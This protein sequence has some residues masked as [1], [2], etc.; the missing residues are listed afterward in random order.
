MHRIQSILFLFVLAGLAGA[1]DRPPD[2]R[3][4]KTPPATVP[5]VD[6]GRYQ[7]LWYEIARYPNGFERDCAGVTAEYAIRPDG[8]VGVTNTCRKGGVDGPVERAQGVARV[9]AGSGNARLTVK[10]APS[11]V[12]FAAGDYWILALDEA[13]ETALVGDPEGRYLWI[14]ARTP[15]ISAQRF[16]NMTAIAARKGYDPDALEMTEHP[17]APAD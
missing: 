6:L 2:H 17:P 14:L 10:F 8:T 11:W 7:G 13:Y 5:E 4:A 15:S 1:C 3:A 9:S 12:P 16:D